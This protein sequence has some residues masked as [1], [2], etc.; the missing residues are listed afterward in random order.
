LPKGAVLIA[1]NLIAVLTIAG[2][3]L[4]GAMSPGQSF[5]LVART[6]VSSSRHAALA[7]S[8]GM[9]VGC[10][11]FAITALTGMYSLLSLVPWLY[12]ALKTAGGFYLLW[13]AFKM[14]SS[15]QFPIMLELTPTAGL[16]MQKAFITGLVTQLSNP[17]TA[18]VFSGI[19]A[20]VLSHKFPIYLYLL[21]P[22]I[23]LAIDLAWYSLVAYLLSS[24]RPRRLYLG[25]SIY[26]DRLGGGLMAFWG[27]RL[28]VN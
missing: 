12:T 10:M 20:A 2:T 28:I 1:G 27:G 8:F 15:I 3:M 23:A 25:Y 5:I 11:I 9:G 4:L 21:L 16:S 24:D 18:L 13:L 17:N 14:F 26:L 6:A 7:V 19:F 22:T